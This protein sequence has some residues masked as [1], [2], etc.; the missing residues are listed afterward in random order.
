MLGSNATGSLAPLEDIFGVLIEPSITRTDCLPAEVSTRTLDAG[1]MRKRLPS[2]SISK[3]VDD[4]VRISSPETTG[5]EGI[6]RKEIC[7]PEMDTPSVAES[8]PT[9]CAAEA[10][11]ALQRTGRKIVYIVRKLN[12]PTIRVYP[13]RK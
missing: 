5:Q 2:P 4:E 11:K 6:P 9:G 10:R 1:A 12:P 3:A 13:H 8:L 7:A